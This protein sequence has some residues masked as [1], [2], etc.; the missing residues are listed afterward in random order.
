M[1]KQLG[2]PLVSSTG[3]VMPL[4]SAVEVNGILYLSGALPLVAGKLAGDDI[5]TQ[6]KA[7]FDNIEALLAKEG[8]TLG[9]VFKITT[10]LT[11][12]EDFAGYNGVYAD[13]LRDPFPARSTV[14]CDL[15]MPGALIE[16]EATAAR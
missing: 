5:E 1:F 7:V 10:W 8:L 11:R 15:A 2:G 16:V 14:I 9:H 6:T 3:A 4:S 12:K 13:R